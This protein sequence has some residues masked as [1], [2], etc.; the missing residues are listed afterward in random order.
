MVFSFT[1]SILTYERLRKDFCQPGQC[2]GRGIGSSLEEMIKEYKVAIKHNL[3]AVGNST[4]IETIS[5]GFLG[6]IR[7]VY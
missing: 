3:A 6:F 2:T 7:S 1:T 5:K 4:N